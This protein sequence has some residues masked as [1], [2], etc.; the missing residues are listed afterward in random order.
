MAAASR[1]GTSKGLC[2]G[3]RGRGW[4]WSCEQGPIRGQ[5]LLSAVLDAVC[6]S[7]LLLSPP[8]GSVLGS[9]RPASV[10]EKSL[11][12]GPLLPTA[13][14]MERWR[15]VLVVEASGGG[16]GGDGSNGWR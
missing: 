12:M 7:V 2:W 16:D 3:H 1:R 14:V 13:V 11:G 10:K 9:W 6:G 4:R 8:G 15:E 5:P